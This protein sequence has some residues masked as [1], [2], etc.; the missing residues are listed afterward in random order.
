VLEGF[1]WD[2]DKA[3]ANL[4]KHGVSFYEAATA[5]LDELA[6]VREDEIHSEEE[7]RYILIGRSFRGRTLVVAHAV[8]GDR[9]RIISARVATPAE[10]RA[11][12]KGP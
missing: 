8:R 7:I 3:E 5:V 4:Q 10:T 1:E 11:Y 9:V 6:Q 12:E 2:P